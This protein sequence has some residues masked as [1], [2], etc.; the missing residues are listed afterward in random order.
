LFWG[1][2]FDEIAIAKKTFNPFSPTKKKKK[3]EKPLFVF[4]LVFWGFD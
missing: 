1:E 4:I 3:K 2:N